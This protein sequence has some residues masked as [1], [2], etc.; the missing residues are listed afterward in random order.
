M[1]SNSPD[2][3]K[4]ESDCDPPPKYSE[5]DMQSEAFNAGYAAANSSSRVPCLVDMQP[6][7]PHV[8]N[9]PL[10]AIVVQPVSRSLLLPVHSLAA[11]STRNA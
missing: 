10:A 11:I 5:I 7:V 4:N 6:H 3:P 1:S 2:N 9:V 8:P